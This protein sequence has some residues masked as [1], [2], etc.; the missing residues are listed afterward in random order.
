MAET[1]IESDPLFTLLTDALRAGPGSPQWSQAVAKLR[2]RGTTGD[3]MATLIEARK[4]LEAGREYRT[5]RA[6]A[7]FTRKVMAEVD[8]TS[9][10]SG[11]G[12]P[13]ANLVAIVSA[14]VIVAVLGMVAYLLIPTEKKLD[15]VAELTATYFPHAIQTLKFDGP[16]P[17]DWK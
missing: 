3:D 9:Q 10:D 6:G 15:G 14:V 2:E 11:G 7:G 5:V 16:T 13:T 12:V 4:N 8:R 17:A 1:A